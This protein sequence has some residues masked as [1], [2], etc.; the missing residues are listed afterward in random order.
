MS[1]PTPR[2]AGFGAL[3][4]V[5]AIMPVGGA[6]AAEEGVGVTESTDQVFVVVAEPPVAS[7]ESM[8]TEEPPEG[9]ASV[10]PDPGSLTLVYQTASGMLV[11]EALTPGSV[12]RGVLR[13]IEVIDTRLDASGWSVTATFADFSGEAGTIPVSQL[14][15]RAEAV[16]AA[17]GLVFG[18]IVA[19]S[20]DA[21]PRRLVAMAPAGMGSG[22]SIVDL[23][24]ELFIPSGQ[25][26]GEYSTTVTIDLVGS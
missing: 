11:G 10:V 19:G 26:A 9:A 25:S 20:A 16:S 15:S 12:A 21:G 17:T 24:M 1:M 5:L 22:S 23:G 7:A 4:V 18:E 8:A 2:C 14:S 13:G 3:A 6:V